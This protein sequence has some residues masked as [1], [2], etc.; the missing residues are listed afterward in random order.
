MEF[1]D[2]TNEYVLDEHDQAMLAVNWPRVPMEDVRIL[3]EANR[4]LQKRSAEWAE[5]TEEAGALAE[6]SSA[7]DVEYSKIYSR[8]LLNLIHQHR[9]RTPRQQ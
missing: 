9:P 4:A 1:D 3:L 7:R 5:L 2:N 8:N 6:A